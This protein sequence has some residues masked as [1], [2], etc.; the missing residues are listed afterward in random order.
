[1][2]KKMKPSLESLDIPTIIANHREFLKAH[3]WGEWKLRDLLTDQRK[4]LPQPPLQK[5]YPKDAELIDLVAPDDFRIGGM[6][7]VEAISRRRSRRE[8]TECDFTLEEF[9]FLLWATQGVHTLIREGTA[10]SRTVPSGGARHPFETYLFVQHVQ[11]LEKGLYRYLAVEH[12][13]L[14][15]Y[16]DAQLTE[17]IH[18][19]CFQAF[20]QHASVIFIW[21]TI[22]YRTEWRYSF[23]AHKVIAQEV[24]HI[25]QNLYLAC[26]SIGAGACALGT[27]NQEAID[28]LMGVDGEDEFAIYIAATGKVKS[29]G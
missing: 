26:E 25:C 1:M 29:D 22:P 4:N 24:G 20:V 6:P 13:L 14:F 7:L 10:T 16:T 18:K 15:L 2:L 8:F 9:S 19:A 23:L 3:L 11:G 12:K 27:Y 17:K 28:Q 21:T 5:P